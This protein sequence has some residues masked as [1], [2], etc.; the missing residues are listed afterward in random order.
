MVAAD[1]TATSSIR[2]LA[3]RTSVLSHAREPSSIGSS[4]WRDRPAEERQDAHGGIHAQS[5]VQVNSPR[6]RC[7]TMV[8]PQPVAGWNLQVEDVRAA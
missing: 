7:R 1:I 4:A 3:K 6:C 5:E 2:W 8:K